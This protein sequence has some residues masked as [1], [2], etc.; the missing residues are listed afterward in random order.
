MNGTWTETV[1]FYECTAGVGFS[2]PLTVDSSD[3]V[4]MVLGGNS[5]YELV[6]GV[7]RLLYTFP[8]HSMMSG[9][10]LDSAGNLYGTTVEGGI[11]GWGTVYKLAARTYTYTDLHDFNTNDPAGYQPAPEDQPAVDSSGNVYGTC[12]NGGT[13]NSG[14]LWK[15]TQ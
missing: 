7:G 1:L 6:E 3:D 2:A 9:V 14:T 15:V 13:H 8:I 5:I 4:F 11:Y 10:T 12:S